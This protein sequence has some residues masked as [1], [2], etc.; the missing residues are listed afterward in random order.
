MISG[1]FLPESTGNW[2][3]STGKNPEDFRSEIRF[4]VPEISGVF[5]QDQMTFAHLSAGFGGRNHRHG[6]LTKWANIFTTDKGV[7]IAH[8]HKRNVDKKF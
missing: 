6:F 7:C 1:R 8:S 4:H 5:L 2:Q 3:K